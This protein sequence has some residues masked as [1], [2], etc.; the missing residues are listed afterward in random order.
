MR[1]FYVPGKPKGKQ[2]PG[3]AR[4]TARAYTPKKTREYEK[5]IAFAYVRQCGEQFQGPVQVEIE[6]VFN[7]PKSWSRAKKKRAVEGYIYPGR[8]D[9]DNIEKAV[10]DGLNRVAYKDDASVVGASCFKGYSVE[11]PEGLYITISSVGG[12][13]KGGRK[14]DAAKGVQR[15]HES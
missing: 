12:G 4:K 5:L 15:N 2:R 3:F 11:Q 8:P 7:P 9:V 1:S 10:L 6:A 13:Q 14:K